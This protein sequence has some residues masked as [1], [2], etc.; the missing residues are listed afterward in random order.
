MRAIGPGVPEGGIDLAPYA[1]ELGYELRVLRLSHAFGYELAR[2]KGRLHAVNPSLHELPMLGG[3]RVCPHDLSCGGHAHD[4]QRTIHE[5]LVGQERL[6]HDR[7]KLI[8]ALKLVAQLLYLA[9]EASRAREVDRT[10]AHAA[11]NKGHQHEAD[12]IA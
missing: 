9:I 2:G 12:S 8:R 5:S 3:L 10:R 1:V 4:L 7:V 11:Y 6:G